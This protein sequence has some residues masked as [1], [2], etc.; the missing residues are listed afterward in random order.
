MRG[1]TETSAD[2]ESDHQGVIDEFSATMATGNNC[3]SVKVRMKAKKK[4]VQP[5][6]M[7]NNHT[8]VKEAV[9]FI[10]R[11]TSLQQI[12][13]TLSNFMETLV[14]SINSKEIL[15]S[16]F[17]VIALLPKVY[18]EQKHKKNYKKER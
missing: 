16:D 17:G 8:N 15:N 4:S 11:D 18:F 10:N 3:T 13:G 2:A 6:I 9:A 1:A 12:A 5:K 7:Q 14:Q